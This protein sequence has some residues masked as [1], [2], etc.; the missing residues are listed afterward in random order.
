MTDLPTTASRPASV[1][2]GAQAPLLRDIEAARMLGISRSKFHTLVASGEIRRLKLGRCARYRRS[3]V[4]Q[5]IEGLVN[6]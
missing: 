6:V 5:F 1:S 4:E 2:L 3:D